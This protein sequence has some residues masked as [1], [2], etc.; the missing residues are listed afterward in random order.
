MES[1]ESNLPPT[2]QPVSIA[3]QAQKSLF[4]TET[5]D[6]PSKGLVYPEGHPLSNGKIEM[7]YMTAREE[8]ILTNQSYIA[9]G[10]MIDKLLQSLIVTK[11]DYNDLVVGD[12]NALLIAARILGYGKDYEFEY[13]GESHTIDLTVLE[14]KI[15]DESI[16]NKGTN[17]FYYTLPHSGIEIT[18]RLLDGHTEK[19]IDNEI[20]GLKKI[21]KNSS[22]ELTTRLKHIITSV[23]G[24]RTPKTIRE[25]IDNN[26]LARDSKALRD[27]IAKI[28]PDIDMEV[29]IEVEE[30]MIPINI[31][32]G[33]N[34]FFPE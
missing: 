11:V 24:D 6:L 34:F 30:R 23:N 10:T 2:S 33:V 14:N 32:L 26:L 28:Q 7:K 20:K 3:P 21:N 18:F 29:Q 9:N 5:I 31:P 25:F 13:A 22:A 15:I 4:P 1:N 19:K 16:F 12:K 27:Y 17:E 8:D